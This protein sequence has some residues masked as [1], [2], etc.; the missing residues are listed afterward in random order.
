[1]Q[2]LFREFLLRLGE[3]PEREGLK[4][5]PKRIEEAFTFLTSG[6]RAD[7]EPYSNDS[8][9]YL[10]TWGWSYRIRT[11]YLYFRKIEYPANPDINGRWE[12]AGIYFGE[13]L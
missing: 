13:R 8:E 2:P 1:M 3:D 6:Y 10:R 9:A 4:T 11:W 7:L 5:T 12:W